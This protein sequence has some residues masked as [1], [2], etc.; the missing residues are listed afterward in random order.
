MIAVR[1]LIWIL[2][3]LFFGGMV[4]SAIVVLLTGV[5]DLKEVTGGHKDDKGNKPAAVAPLSSPREH[6]A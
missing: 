6:T 4:G 1:I 2:E 5:E 3:V